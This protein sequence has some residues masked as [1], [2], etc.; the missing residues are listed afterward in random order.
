MSYYQI[1]YMI[2]FQI[3]LFSLDLLFNSHNLYDRTQYSPE[4]S[5]VTFE[6]DVREKGLHLNMV[7]CCHSA[8]GLVGQGL[9]T[10][11]LSYDKH[12]TNTTDKLFPIRQ[13]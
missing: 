1:G 4:H 9:H 12:L 10:G 7:Y 8:R 11:F 6:C 3:K 13:I 5:S 2:R